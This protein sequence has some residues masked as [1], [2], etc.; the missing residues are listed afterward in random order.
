M[1]LRVALQPRLTCR[2]KQSRPTPYG[3]TTPMPVIATRGRPLPDIAPIIP[4]LMASDSARVQGRAAVFAWGG[5][6][7]FAGSLLFFLY[8]YLIRFGRLAAGTGSSP[9][10]RSTTSLF[11]R[12]RAAPQPVRAAG[13]EALAFGGDRG[14]RSTGSSA[15]LYTW[16]ASLLFIAVCAAWRRRPGRALS[17][18]RR[19]SRSRLC[20]SGRRH[21][22]HGARLGAPR[23]ARPRRRARRPLPRPRPD[24]HGH[25]PL[26]SRAASTASSATRSTSRG[27]CSSSARRT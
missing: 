5:A 12:L 2:Q 4:T 17:A 23:R 20:R 27:R 21:R 6:A 1:M 26:Q 24:S 10:S 13:G 7:L 11:T 22:A 3:E 8:C 25:V 15:R 9:P 14:R 18:D 16:V 19:R